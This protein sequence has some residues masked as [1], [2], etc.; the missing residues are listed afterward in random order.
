M[1]GSLIA[2]SLMLIIFALT[3]AMPVMGA[4]TLYGSWV[5]STIEGDNSTTV[6]TDNTTTEVI[7]LGRNY[8]YVSIVLPTINSCNITVKATR[9]YNG[10]TDN[11]TFVNIGVATTLIAN[12]TGGAW[13]TVTLNGVRWLQLTC[14]ENQTA[15]RTFYLRGFDY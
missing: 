13:E 3:F 4:D 8:R 1:K 11:G 12:S 6:W 2:I 15:A 7:D 5:S 9:T 10:T 14:S